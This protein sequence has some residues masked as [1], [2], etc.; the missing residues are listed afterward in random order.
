MTIA[1][2]VRECEFWTVTRGETLAIGSTT[3]KEI[4]EL[5]GGLLF[6][7]DPTTNPGL[8]LGWSITV[9]RYIRGEDEETVENPL[10][11]EIVAEIERRRAA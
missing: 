1:E 11:T 10:Y 7:T 9:G 5:F 4:G 8:R 6:D 2:A 3:Q